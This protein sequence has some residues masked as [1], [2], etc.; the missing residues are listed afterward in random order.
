MSNVKHLPIIKYG[1]NHYSI[2]GN[3]YSLGTLLGNK[4]PAG[5]FMS[6]NAAPIAGVAG[7]AGQAMDMVLPEDSVGGA[8]LGGAAK[9]AASLAMLGPLGMAAGAIGGGLMGGLTQNKA[10]KSA[11]IAREQ[12]SL[13]KYGAI[14]G[15]IDPNATGVYADG[16]ELPGLTSFNGGFKHADGSMLNVNQ[17]IPQGVS[18]ENG[19]PNIVENGETRRNQ[20]VFSDQIP[21]VGTKELYLPGKYEGKTFAEASKLASNYIKERPND[22]IAKKGQEV[23]LNRLEMANNEAKAMKEAAGMGYQQEEQPQM[24]ACGGKLC[25]G[26]SLKSVFAHGGY[27]FTDY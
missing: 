17:G 16:G 4:S 1:N 8:A 22:P 24:A 20:F 10:N 15:Q 25:G 23:A 6:K 18:S 14:R 9:G 13:D 5:E 27:T 26:G 21:V 7:L 2:G 11:A 12:A 3:M 19:K